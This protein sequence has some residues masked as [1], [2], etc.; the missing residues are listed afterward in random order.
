[1]VRT[2]LPRSRE[3]VVIVVAGVAGCG[4]LPADTPAEK[5]APVDPDIAILAHAWKI[6]GHVLASHTAM[7]EADARSLHGRTIHIRDGAYSSPWHGSCEESARVRRRTTLGDVTSELDID[8]RA[9]DRLKKLGVDDS[10]VEFKLQCTKRETPEL[11]VFVGGA[12]A[13]TCWTGVCY[14]LAR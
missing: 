3:L 1:V 12:H 11:T 13:M 10:L 2:L 7:T 8:V 6:G 4:L 5:P 9:R 14:V